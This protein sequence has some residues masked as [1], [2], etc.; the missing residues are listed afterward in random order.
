MAG[1]GRGRQERKEEEDGP[2]A[3]L[4]TGTKNNSTTRG[5]FQGGRGTHLVTCYSTVDKIM[6]ITFWY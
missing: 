2:P 5:D 1:K 6:N 4:V 3:T